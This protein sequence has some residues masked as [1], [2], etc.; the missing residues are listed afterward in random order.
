MDR[1]YDAYATMDSHTGS[2]RIDK[3]KLLNSKLTKLLGTELLKLMQPWTA[4]LGLA[5]MARKKSEHPM[6]K[7]SR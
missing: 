4:I 7:A 1:S 5:E 6:Y 3:K 2:C